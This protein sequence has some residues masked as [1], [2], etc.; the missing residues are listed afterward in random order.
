MSH[1]SQNVTDLV[2]IIDMCLAQTG[3]N[4]TLRDT[5]E[6]S[7]FLCADGRFFKQRR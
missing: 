4:A 7:G 2:M 1:R 3:F 6:A 5:G